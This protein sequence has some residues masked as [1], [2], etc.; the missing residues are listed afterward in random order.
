MVDGKSVDLGGEIALYVEGNFYVPRQLVKNYRY[1]T[2]LTNLV[3]GGDM[4]GQNCSAY[5]FSS[6]YGRYETA[7]GNTYYKVASTE[8]YRAT[9]V[10]YIGDSELTD[11]KFRAIADVWTDDGTTHT[12]FG[13]GYVWSTVKAPA[14]ING[15]KKTVDLSMTYDGTG[16]SVCFLI[17]QTDETLKT[18]SMDN[19]SLFDLTNAYKITTDDEITIDKASYAL[20][21]KDKMTNAGDTVRFEVGKPAEGYVITGVSVEGADVTEE[22]DGSY[23]FTMPATDTKIVVTKEKL[24]Y[25]TSLENLISGGD[26]EGQNSSVYAGNS[27]YGSYQTADGNTYY[28]VASTN[29]SDPRAAVVLYRPDTAPTGRTFRAVADVWTDDGATHSDFGLGYAWNTVK[30]AATI[31]G[32]KKTVDLSMTYEDTTVKSICLLIKSAGKKGFSMDNAS[33]YDVTDAYKLIADEEIII[34]SASYAL[35]GKDKMANAGDTIKFTVG[36]PANGYVVTG[37]SVDGADV[38]KEADGS[39]TFTMPA[40]D[41][42]ITVIK[43]KLAYAT[44]LENLITGGDME[45]QNSSVYAGNSEYGSYQTVDGNTYYKVASTNTSDPRAAVVLGRIDPAP[46]GRKFRVIADVWT[47]D[48]ATYSDFGLGHAWNVVKESTTISGEKKTVDLSMTYEDTTVKSIC[49]LIK[50]AGKKSF[51][52]D[53]AAMYDVTNAYKLTADDEITID[54]ASYTVIGKDKMANAGDTVKIAVGEPDAGYI[55]TGVSVEGA[56]VTKEADGSY[57]FTMPAA[58]TKIVVN[59]EKLAHRTSL[60][61]LISGGNME[62]ENCSISIANLYNTLTWSYEEDNDGL[63]GKVLKVIDTRENGCITYFNSQI[64]HTYAINAN[65]KTDSKVDV[66]V[67][68]ENFGK[69]RAIIS[70]NSWARLSVEHTAIGEKT[71][72]WHNAANNAMYLDGLSVYDITNAKRITAPDEIVIDPVSYIVYKGKKITNAGDVVKFTAP[73]GVI[74]KVNDEI[75]TPD[76]D[77]SYTFTMPIIDAVI[78]TQVKEVDIKEVN[79]DSKEAVISSLNSLS[80]IVFA[81]SYDEYDKLLNVV[82]APVTVAAGGTATIDLSAFDSI[83][84]V[85]LFIWNNLTDIKPVTESYTIPAV[86]L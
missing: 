38:T 8:A 62:K 13:L 72:I 55:I 10:L 1:R 81:A 68:S 6:K 86:Q 36:E 4:E 2:S 37:V 46:T 15:T 64:G 25:V 22:T 17:P 78:T 51:S 57:T 71:W 29:A 52:M 54:S 85:R 23:T 20:V 28:K 26:M 19:L 82:S 11:R 77:G 61:N 34:N 40:A 63:Y 18:F 58:D 41:A 32:A 44:S 75:I 24:A 56:D 59:K 5:S 3:S 42:K 80:C 7:N 73:E 30:A 79:Y 67:A 65:V 14:T 53:N 9:A 69:N 50:S 76:S 48:N 45:G 33:I 84:G 66:Y 39:Y 74:V 83:E 21:G 43:E 31:S 47:E 70:T 60:E 49:L 27:E 12:D 16:K 35:I